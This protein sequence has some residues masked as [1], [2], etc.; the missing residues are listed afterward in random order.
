[1][2]VE[3]RETGGSVTIDF[4]SNED[5]K[6]LMDLMEANREKM[7]DVNMMLRF[8]NAR[9][10]L[11]A[12][13]SDDTSISSET[14]PIDDRSKEEVKAAEEESDLYNIKNFSL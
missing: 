5:L 10:A 11:P 7:G 6:T 14:T 13:P 9:E 1:V 3:R 12:A 4:F 8:E 2:H